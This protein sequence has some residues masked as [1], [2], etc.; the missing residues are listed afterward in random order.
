MTASILDLIDNVIDECLST[1]AM[2]WSPDAPDPTLSGM[3]LTGEQVQVGAN[4]SWVDL[5]PFVTVLDPEMVLTD[6]QTDLLERLPTGSLTLTLDNSTSVFRR[7]FDQ[8]SQALNRFTVPLSQLAAALASA[9]AATRRDDERR[10]R[11][12]RMH[13]LYHR[14]RS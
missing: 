3:V 13:T 10:A 5:T 8:M 6:W 1:D 2:R 9:D 4:G 12:S 7:A 14:R 11:L